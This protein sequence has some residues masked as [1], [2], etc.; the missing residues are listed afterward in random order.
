MAK[1]AAGVL[2]SLVVALSHFMMNAREYRFRQK[3][4]CC[5]VGK[6]VWPAQYPRL[7]VLLSI[8]KGMSSEF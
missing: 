3:G 8:L 5:L 6:P 4:G 1:M 7:P 2:V